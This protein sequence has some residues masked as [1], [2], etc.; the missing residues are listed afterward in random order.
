MD[1]D[2]AEL[3]I[4]SALELI[5]A[6]EISAAVL[7]SAC[8]DQIERVN[9][10]INAFLRVGDR[11]KREAATTSGALPV[12]V[13]VKDLIDVAGLRTT[14]G[15]PMFFGD[16]PAEEDA[17]VVT[18]LRLSG[19]EIIGKTN[20]HEIALGVTG[21]NP[22][23]GPVRNPHNLGRISGGSSSGSAAAVATGMAFAALGTDTGGS[24]RIP[25]ALC[26]VVGLKPTLGR[27]STRGVLPLSWNLDHVGPLTRSVKDAALLLQVM[28]GY[29]ALD[30]ACADVTVDDYGVHLEEGIRDWR[31]AVGV[32]EYIETADPVILKA[33]DEAAQALKS[34]GAK[35]GKMDLSWIIDLAHANA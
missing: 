24:I 23:F 33:V 15:S 35:I 1:I 3:S 30:P 18:K 11:E 34:N 6:G 8:H 2:P 32:G 5:R 16:K 28:A 4:T 27:V 31:V 21:V 10:V 22:H 12:P 9:P 20:T 25:A 29:D 17:C 13:A 26:G 14:A 19:A 7:N